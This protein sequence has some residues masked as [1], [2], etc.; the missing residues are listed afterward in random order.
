MAGESLWLL[1]QPQRLGAHA[2]LAGADVVPL[3][4][5]W[6]GDGAATVA[7]LQRRTGDVWRFATWDPDGE[8]TA[9]P[10]G[11]FPG[12][13][14]LDRRVAVGGDLLVVQLRSGAS[15]VVPAG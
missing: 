15:T 7:L 2:D 10:V 11:H 1:A 12:A 5:D 3:V 14:D 8:V 13:V 6:D 4:G 9:E